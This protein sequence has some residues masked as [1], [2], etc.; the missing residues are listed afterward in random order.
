MI[1]APS[2]CRR[3]KGRCET[4]EPTGAPTPTTGT[5]ATATEASTTPAPTTPPATAASPPTPPP[6]EATAEK[7]AP[8]PAAVTLTISEAAR[9][10]DVNRRTIRHHRQAGDFPGAFKDQDGMWRIPVEDLEWV[11]LHADLGRASEDPMAAGKVDLL[12]TE[13][14]VLRERLRAA[15]LIATEREKR[16]DDLRLI[17]RMLPARSLAASSVG[18]TAG[19]LGPRQGPSP[20]GLTAGSP[21]P[22]TAS[23]QTAD[24]ES[25]PVIWLPDAPEARPVPMERPV[26]G[27]ENDLGSIWTPGDSSVH[28]DEAEE[29]LPPGEPAEPAPRF[30]GPPVETRGRR[31]RWLPWRRSR[32]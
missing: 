27:P 12:R 21:S 13:V 6:T 14:A 9:A 4:L 8:K 17:L 11:G 26:R 25:E 16:I 32:E 19:R 22:E 2:R 18:R 5:A 10:C 31:K 23:A 20:A 1:M 24:A 15:E 7:P 28:R 30:Y 3:A 29:G